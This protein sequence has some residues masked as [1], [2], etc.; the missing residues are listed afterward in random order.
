[1]CGRRAVK[2]RSRKLPPPTFLAL[3]RQ[4]R[5]RFQRGLLGWLRAPKDGSGIGE[6][7]EAVRHIEETQD[8]PSARAFWWITTGVF[9]ALAEG[10]LAE[11]TASVK[12]LCTRVDLQIRRLLEGSKNVAERLMR[13]ALYFVARADSAHPL[14]QQIKNVYQL[15][16]VMPPLATAAALA[17]EASQVVRRRLGELISAAEE[18]WS[19]YCVGGAQSLPVFH[20]ERERPER[21][22]RAAGEHRF[23]AARASDRCGGKL[24]VG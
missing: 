3:L 2:H 15:Q 17:G 18:A 10:T 11:D 19:K 20:A 21:R 12:Q 23:Q 7:L 16:A 22:C 4:E 1:M 5:A 24:V 13:D 9:H 8:A 6:M 14:V